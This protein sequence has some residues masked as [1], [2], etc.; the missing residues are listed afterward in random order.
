M[1]KDIRPPEPQPIDK[2]SEEQDEQPPNDR[3]KDVPAKTWED[4]L[5]E[6]RFESTDN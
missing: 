3:P 2:E 4:A 5:E 6:D 1:A